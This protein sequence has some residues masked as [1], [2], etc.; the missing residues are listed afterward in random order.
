MKSESTRGV[1]EIKQQAFKQPVMHEQPAMQEK[2]REYR[3]SDRQKWEKARKALYEYW[4]DL[5]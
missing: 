5:K 1:P 4:R 2:I 3:A